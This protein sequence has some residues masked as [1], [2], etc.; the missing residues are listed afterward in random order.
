MIILAL[1]NM[2]LPGYKAGGPIQSVANLTERL[3]EGFQIKIIT[4]DRDYGDSKRYS[5]VRPGEWQEIGKARVLYVRPADC[6]MWNLRR[7]INRT[8]YDVLYLNSFFHPCLLYTSD[9]AAE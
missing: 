6:S 3:G 1:V 5:S 9:A 2:Y 4:T 7:I 8:E